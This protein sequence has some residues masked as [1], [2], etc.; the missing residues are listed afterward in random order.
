MRTRIAKDAKITVR[1]KPFV[2]GELKQLRREVAERMRRPLPSQDDIVA[3]L[4][5]A[6]TAAK[7]APALRAYWDV[8]KPWEDEDET[9][10]AD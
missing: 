3:A 4:I 6:A 2:P 5:H 10:E 9:D 7:L 1:V 8:A